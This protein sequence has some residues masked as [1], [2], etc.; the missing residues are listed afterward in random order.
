MTRL[1]KPFEYSEPRSIEE[2]VQFLLI[3]GNKAKIIAGYVKIIDTVIAA[4]ETMGKG[5]G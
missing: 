3:H 5:D 4:A 1:L 2:A